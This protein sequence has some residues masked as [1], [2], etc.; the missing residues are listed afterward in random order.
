MKY[1]TSEVLSV[2]NVAAAWSSLFP[3]HIKLRKSLPDNAICFRINPLV[4]LKKRVSRWDWHT[5]SVV[6]RKT[7]LKLQGRYNM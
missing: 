5:L 3:S 2:Q 4:R 6:C 1:Q 7:L